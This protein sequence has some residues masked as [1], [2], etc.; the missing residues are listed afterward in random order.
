M[1]IHHGSKA[2]QGLLAGAEQLRRAVAI[3]LGPK[4]RNVGI[5]KAIGDPLITKDGVSVA[6]EIE[7]PSA[8][9]EMGARL[10][11]EVAAE[12]SH[13]AGDG[14]T[15]ATVL[16]TAM[17]REGM[18]LVE[19]GYP[20]VELARAMNETAQKVAEVIRGRAIP[21]RAQEFIARIATVSANGDEQLGNLLADCIVKAG[22]DG[23]IHIDESRGIETSV[24]YVDGF[25]FDQ[26]W[27]NSEFITEEATRSATFDFPLV[28]V[29]DLPI[30]AARPL[31][32]LL[33][34]VQ[35]ADRPLVVIA[36]EVT[37]E[38][39]QLLIQNLG[40]VRSVACKPPVTGRRQS[41]VLRDIA[42]ATGARFLSRAE[43]LTFDGAFASD[44]LDCLGTV[45]RV[46]VT[47]NQTTLLEGVGSEESVEQRVAG[48]MSERD[49]LGS[50]YEQDQMTDRIAAL[51]GGVCLIKIGG[52]SEVEIKELKARMEDALSATQAALE[53]GVV[54]GGGA[55][56]LWAADEVSF[57]IEDSGLSETQKHGAELVLSTAAAPFRQIVQNARQSADVWQH[58]LLKLDD[59]A[60]GLDI[61]KLELVDMIVNG[62]LDPA[63][64]PATA[65]VKAAS[66]AGTLLTTE[67]CVSPVKKA[68]VPA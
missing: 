35:E 25:R 5:D 15:T 18:K 41:E 14:T 67:V 32:P 13:T 42:V 33:E 2:R 30:T 54:P 68:E 16:A 38:G 53:S 49:R 57:Q 21:V 51:V 61:R 11:K 62:I 59:P 66:L 8:L 17:I 48:I 47:A 46:E 24:E 7:L 27:V 64:V 39:L 4:G 10:V 52:H 40:N 43:G 22:S 3:T 28:L 50:G 31:L 65:V 60:F 44:P 20:P 56:L 63:S 36:P 55:A 23:I 19:A 12:T 29:T 58:E 37:G 26:G 6:N 1:P 45:R 34:A 9:E